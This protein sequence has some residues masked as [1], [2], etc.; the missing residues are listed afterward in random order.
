MVSWNAA[1][2]SNNDALQEAANKRSGEHHHQVKDK[3]LRFDPSS[4]KKHFPAPDGSK[5]TIDLLYLQLFLQH[6]M[7]QK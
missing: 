1:V 4:V 3:P 2:T 7:N 6:L 5:S